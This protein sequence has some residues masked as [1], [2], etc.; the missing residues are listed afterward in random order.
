MKHNGAYLQLQKAVLSHDLTAENGVDARTTDSSIIIY[1]FF[2]GFK[3]TATDYFLVNYYLIREY[4]NIIS[5]VEVSQET[6][7]FIVDS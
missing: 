4:I 1:H 7:P 6:K 2:F 3:G 5:R